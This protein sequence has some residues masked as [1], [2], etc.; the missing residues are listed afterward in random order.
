METVSHFYTPEEIFNLKKN[1]YVLPEIVSNNLDKIMNVLVSRN[2]NKK[3]FSKYSSNNWSTPKY[4][5]VIGDQ[6]Q[7]KIKKAI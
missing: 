4:I 1:D 7:Q 3:T 2:N 5:S 6:N